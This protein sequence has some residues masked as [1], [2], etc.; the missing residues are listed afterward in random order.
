MKRR[1]FLTASVLAGSGAMFSSFTP[2]KT[3]QQLLEWIQ[4][5]FVTNAKR[6]KLED[7]LGDVVVP[8]LNKQGCSPI[9]GFRPMYGAHG[10]DL[11]MLIPHKSFDSMLNAWNNLVED[12]AFAKAADSSINDPLYYRMESSLMLAFEDLP[13]IE[14]PENI[15]GKQGRI[16]EIRTYE[17]HNR[18]KG[19]L[20][21]EMFN[22]GGEIALFKKTGL[23]P[24]FFGETIVGPLMPN[25]TY[26]LGFENIDQRNANWPVFGGSDEWKK[27]SSNPRYAETVS[28]ITDNILTAA[29]FSQ[30]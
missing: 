4:F 30:I 12:T 29:S 5:K 14:V 23:N 20:K 28:N 22:D 9:G 15:K 11:F 19:K 21:V 24:V 27:M 13:T 18:L 25:L 2:K 8:G 26:M 7:F 1:N 17:S 10:G 16:F 6:G 3:D